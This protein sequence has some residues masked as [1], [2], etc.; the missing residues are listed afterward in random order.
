MV[1]NCCSPREVTSFGC[2]RRAVVLRLAG[3][4]PVCDKRGARNDGAL[5]S[6]DDTTTIAADD[7]DGDGVTTEGEQ[8]V[9]GMLTIKS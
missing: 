6:G 1:L 3:L 5:H 2:C 9:V 8:T 4:A 7:D